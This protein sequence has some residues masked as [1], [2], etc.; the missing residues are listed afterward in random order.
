MSE[1]IELFIFILF[2]YL[3]IFYCSHPETLCRRRASKVSYRR[4]LTTRKDIPIGQKNIN[5]QTVTLL[6]EVH[7]QFQLYKE[8]ESLFAFY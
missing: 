3:F 4:S 6:I 5:L 2:H 8:A 1:K 7:C